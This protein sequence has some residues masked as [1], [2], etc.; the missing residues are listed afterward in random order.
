MKSPRSR[1]ASASAVEPGDVLG[2]FRG[3]ELAAAAVLLRAGP[4]LRGGLR[5]AGPVGLGEHC[6]EG[7]NVG[8]NRGGDDVRAPG[9][10][11][12]APAGTRALPARRR[13]DR[14]LHLALRVRALGKGV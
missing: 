12:V 7:V 1:I 13:F 6:V 9:R 8:L 2:R 5:R 14:D 10:A 3:V 11:L 4:T